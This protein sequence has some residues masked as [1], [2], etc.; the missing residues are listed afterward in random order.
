MMVKDWSK[1]FVVL[2]GLLFG[3]SASLAGMAVYANRGSGEVIEENTEPEPVK[4]ALVG[5][6]ITEGYGG[7]PYSDSMQEALGA[8]YEVLN[9]GESGA[10]ASGWANLP[11]KDTPSY[12]E[13]RDAKA[14]IVIIQLGT[15][16]TVCWLN[17]TSFKEAY[18][19]LISD[20]QSTGARVILA[21]PPKAYSN[22]D[23]GVDTDRLEAIVDII[24][25]L[26]ADNGLAVVD[27]YENST[28]DWLSSDGVH[29]NSYGSQMAGQLMAQVV[30]DSAV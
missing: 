8:G 20:Y 12:K 1:W 26:A 11:Y 16:D 5:D 19:G 6:S 27:M 18:N 29:L 23:Y 30:I 21:T 17:E 14:D 7:H 3:M 9:F 13:S 2:L 15:N 24:Q 25:K 22:G 28:Y 10:S 4:V